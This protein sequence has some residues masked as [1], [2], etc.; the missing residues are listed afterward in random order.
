MHL[1]SAKFT[2]PTQEATRMKFEG[3]L[4]AFVYERLVRFFIKELIDS[5]R[6]KI[7]HHLMVPSQHN[8]FT[9]QST[10]VF[11]GSVFVEH[12]DNLKAPHEIRRSNPQ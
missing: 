1:L 5:K 10:T 8:P 7:E 12:P 11:K 2:M 9:E 4:E 6:I 3:T